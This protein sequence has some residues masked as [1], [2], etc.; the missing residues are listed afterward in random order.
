MSSLVQ[1]V[2]AALKSPVA[3]LYGG[4]ASER[5]VSL[6]SGSFCHDA[7]VSAGVDA[8]LV[9]TRDNWMSSLDSAGIQHCFIALHGPGGEDGT[10]QGALDYLG[11]SYTGSGVLASA[12]AMD[13]WRTKLL[14][15]G[16]GLQVPASEL[17]NAN[18][19]WQACLSS[20]GGKA[21]VK[22]AREGSSIGMSVAA[23]AEELAEAWRFAAQYDDLVFAEQ[24]IEGG[25]YTVGLL[26]EQVLPVI[27]LETDNS[28]YDFDAK[29]LADDTCYLIPSGLSAAEESS[30]SEMAKSAYQAVGCEGWGRV[31]A[32]RDAAG[33]F[34]L[35]E[36]NTVPGMTDHSLVPMAAK[37]AGMSFE[38]LVV[39]ILAESLS[40]KGE[41][42]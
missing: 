22:P 4:S 12:L 10:I 5:E 25:E 39:A 30:L 21:I 23:T 34:Y 11:V 2:N 31:D 17:L 32:M 8:V 3:V 18:S 42:S 28:F 26:G 38:E 15:S 35:L 37:A 33:E 9:D 40:D 14:W 16:L 6:K 27:G 19:N 7:L 1:Q 24:W 13:K 36:V 20:L 29:Y 41:Q